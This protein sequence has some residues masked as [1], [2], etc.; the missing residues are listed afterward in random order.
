MSSQIFSLVTDTQIFF[1]QRT[2]GASVYWFELLK[3]MLQD[4]D[5]DVHLLMADAVYDNLQLSSL[6]L[7]NATVHKE[8]ARNNLEMRLLAPR[9][10]DN[11]QL[12]IL[13]HSSYMRMPKDV[14]DA[15][16]VTVH[17]F[18]HQIF[19]P[20]KKAIPNSLLKRRAIDKADGILSI[21]KST[22]EDLFRLFP[23]A[24]AKQNE[25]IYNGASDSYFIDANAVARKPI[26][27]ACSSPYVLYIGAREGYKNFA[28][29][30][31]VMEQLPAVRLI[32]VGGE[33]DFSCSLDES[34]VDCFSRLMNDDLN[35]L[36]NNAL[37]LF[38]PS[39]YEGFGIP[40]VEATKAGCPVIACNT[41]SI[42]EVASETTI[43]LSPDDV[44]GA[45]SAINWLISN[46]TSNETKVRA[47]KQARRF[48]WDNCYREV[49]AFY[50]R[51][52]FG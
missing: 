34:R 7:S 45:V 32:V 12:P 51:L 18:T 26:M 37:C 20:K 1:T 5:I 48:S 33:S 27:E 50:K 36:Y 29:V 13:F 16:V 42:P 38:Y 52:L 39:L 17:D 44:D 30:E 28:M 11:L 4:S 35:Y 8:K 41:S 9:I 43:L 15:K 49:K 19:F 22:Q 31:K 10:P 46:P 23:Q 24:Y 47:A 40:V 21:S 25:V 6:D 3:R 2:G 14:C